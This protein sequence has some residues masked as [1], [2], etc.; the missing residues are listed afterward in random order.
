[1]LQ[2]RKRYKNRPI[3]GGFKTLAVGIIN[4]TDVMQNSIDRELCLFAVDSNK[5]EGFLTVTNIPSMI[6]VL[7]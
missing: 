2:R 1:M 3:P 6:H 4:L 7:E 5:D